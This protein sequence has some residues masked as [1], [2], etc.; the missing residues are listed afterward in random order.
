M[1][2]CLIAVTKGGDTLVTVAHYMAGVLDHR[3]YHQEALGYWR[4]PDGSYRGG[5]AEYVKEQ[6]DFHSDVIANEGRSRFNIGNCER[7]AVAAGCWVCDTPEQE[8]AFLDKMRRYSFV[9]FAK[10]KTLEDCAL[11]IDFDTHTATIDPE[12]GMIDWQNYL[13]D[14]WTFVLQHP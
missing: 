10:G 13:P 5:P 9:D 11:H 12:N 7:E 3:K 8:D 1:S 4:E 6:I 2:E 14:G